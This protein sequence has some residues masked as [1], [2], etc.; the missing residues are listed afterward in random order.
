MCQDDVAR[1]KGGRDLMENLQQGIIVG[2]KNLQVIAHLSELGWCADEIWDRPRRP[3]PHE[4]VETFIPEVIH[5]PRPDDSETDYTNV[6]LR[7]AGHK[8]RYPLAAGNQS[9]MKRSGTQ[10]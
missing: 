9:E 10:P 7:A 5:H 1:G 8:F 4:N 3:V 2:Y 6:S